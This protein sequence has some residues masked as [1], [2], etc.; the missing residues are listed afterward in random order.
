[1]KVLVVG[2]GGREHALVWKIAQSPKVDKIYCAPGN[3]GIASLAECLPIAAENIEAILSFVEEKDIDLTV[4]GPEAPLALGLTDELEKAGRIVFGPSKA[5]A[6]IESSKE[7][8]KELMQ[9]H[10]IPTAAYAA[11]SNSNEAI[12]YIRK[13]GA[14]LVIK[15]DGLAAGKGVIIAM[16]EQTAIDAVKQ[17]L[18]DDVFGLAGHRVVI[19]EFLEGEE[20]SI[21][22]FCDG[23]HIV[24]MASAQDHKRAYDDD[25][26]PNTGGMGA[27]SPA[28][29]YTQELAEIVEKTILVPSADALR[30]ESRI[31]RGVLYV[32]LMITKDG[33]KVLEYNARFGD[34]ETQPVL[35][36]LKTDLIDIIYAIL[37]GKLDEI[38]IDWDEKPS[39]CVVIASG[40][41]P[42]SYKKGY[43]INGL[44]T[45]ES[46]GAVVFHA[47]TVIKN[48]KVLSSGGRVLGVTATGESIAEAIAKTYRAVEKISFEDSF[49]RKDIGYRALKR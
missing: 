19:E 34:P 31:Y 38:N 32:G 43:E 26:G 29:V 3:A 37:E 10:H 5:A 30:A 17:M 35:M 9:K 28:P 49:Y 24:P 15:A 18:E 23:Y 13:Q 45:A 21:L 33:P 16:D 48:D 4:I 20:V 2:G 36:R 25:L 41:Y 42:G 7:I 22:A 40:G 46:E 8:A 27:Y 11:F 12:A 14:P 1:M 47:G 6:A 44:V 39:V